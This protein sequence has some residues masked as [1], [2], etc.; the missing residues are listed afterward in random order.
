MTFDPTMGSAWDDRS[1][2]V[3]AGSPRRELTLVGPDGASR[4][5]ASGR[6]ELVIGRAP[7][8]DVLIDDPGISRKHAVLRIEPEL[9]IEDLGSAN[10]TR[11]R[12]A[13]IE[14]NREVALQPGDVIDFGAWMIVVQGDTAPAPSFARHAQ[15]EA[16]VE[17]EC[18]RARR[19]KG[20]FAVV[21]LSA[22]SASPGAVRAILDRRLEEGELVAVYAPGDYEIFTERVDALEA[23]LDGIAADLAASGAAARAGIAVYPKDGKSADALIARA[24]AGAIGERD[25]RPN[26]VI[27]EPAM[28]ALHQLV[29]RVAKGSINVL[30]LGETGTGKEIIAQEIHARSR[31]ADGPFVQLNCA[32]LTET[33]LESELFGYEEGAFTGASRA[34]PGLLESANGGTIVLDEVGEMPLGTQVKL[35]RVLEER[36][37]RRVGG[38]E[39]KEIDVRVVASTNRNLAKEAAEGRFRPD[40][41][42]RLDG[43]TITIPPLRERTTEIAELARLFVRNA[44]ERDGFAAPEIDPEAM[45]LLERYAW[46]GN[47]REL[48]NMMERAVLLSGGDRIEPV[49]LPPEKLLDRLPIRGR[50]PAIEDP[51]DEAGDEDAGDDRRFDAG[52]SLGA[53]VQDFERNRILAALDRHDGNQSKAAE[54][55]GIARR[56]LI[57]RLERYAIP[58][59][60]KGA[61]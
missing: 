23:M 33:L 1:T 40:L 54:S 44:S 10:G 20:A 12:G 18:A 55:L 2:L 15:F 37:V 17:A 38:L 57:R 52:A 13:A 27:R 41:Y 3:H 51:P 21:R 35:L 9:A 4:I 25:Q 19:T 26:I 48:R 24:C 42:Y 29:D 8:A 36:K 61:K 32:A 58:R 5:T 53:Q 56:T 31:R 59:P 47:I 28:V 60:R 11:V 50:P 34:K 16:R 46:P 22:A 45:V 39:P 7:D 49:H 30:L 6:R 43:I 14:P